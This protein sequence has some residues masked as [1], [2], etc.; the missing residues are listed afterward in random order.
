MHLDEHNQSE[1]NE[2]H[3][4]IHMRAYYLQ[5]INNQFKAAQGSQK[6]S[7]TTASQT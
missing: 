3:N 5:Y 7:A 4:D 6:T 2:A 1:I